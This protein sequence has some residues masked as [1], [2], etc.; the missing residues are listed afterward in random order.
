MAT[1]SLFI[2]NG[3]IEDYCDRYFHFLSEDGKK[4]RGNG[5]TVTIK[6]SQ[7]GRTGRIICHSEREYSDGRAVCHREFKLADGMVGLSGGN[8]HSRYAY[9]RSEKFSEWLEKNELQCVIRSDPNRVYLS[10]NPYGSVWSHG[11]AIKTDGKVDWEKN[12]YEVS[13]ATFAIVR[14]HY[15]DG[16]SWH[17]EPGVLY[18]EEKDVMSLL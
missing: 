12:R 16:V 5:W 11:L 18:T 7:G 3:R 10:S 9:F 1:T 17:K 14:R 2:K 13:S 6:D 15:C 8:V 4:Y